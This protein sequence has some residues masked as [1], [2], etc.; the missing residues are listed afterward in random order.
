MSEGSFPQIA[1]LKD[2]AFKRV[3]ST[4]CDIEPESRANVGLVDDLCI[5]DR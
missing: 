2:W 5:G 1:T 3:H 4:D